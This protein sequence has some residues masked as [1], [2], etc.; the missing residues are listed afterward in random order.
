MKKTPVLFVILILCGFAASSQTH[1]SGLI[2]AN[3]TWNVAGSPYI[4][5]G[6]TLIQSGVK[7]IVEAGVT[8]KFSDN[9]TLLI[10]G[11]LDAQGDASNHILFTSASTNPSPGHWNN[12]HFSSTS[13]PATFNGDGTYA[14]G[15]IMQYCD[16][17]YGGQ[18]GLGMLEIDNTA[19][20]IVFCSVQYSSCDG[21]YLK[22]GYSKIHHCQISNNSGSGIYSTVTGI[23][24][25]TE[26]YSTR[27]FS[28]GGSGIYVAD[29][30][31]KF[32]SIKSCALTGNSGNGIYIN[33][34][35]GSGSGTINIISDTIADNSADKGAG[36]YINGGFDIN[37]FCNTI[38]HNT[39]NNGS[40]IYLYM[41]YNPYDIRISYNDIHNN[42]SWSGD[43]I[44]LM[45]YTSYTT[46][47][48]LSSNSICSNTAS[49]GNAVIYMKGGIN[50]DI[51]DVK[52][53][54]IRS[55]TGFT[56]FEL[57][58]FNGHINQNNFINDTEYEIYNENPAGTVNV[59]AMDNYWYGITTMDARIY[60]FF[61]N[62]SIS[63][64]YYSPVYADSIA[65]AGCPQNILTHLEPIRNTASGIKVYPNPSNDKITVETTMINGNKR[66]SI[67]NV[68][69]QVMTEREISEPSVQID[70]STFPAGVYF[71]RM[72]GEKPVEV[73]K[74]LKE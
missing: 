56:T 34:N 54:T 21:I 39:G 28:N 73:V 1:I 6:N 44:Y 36:I 4:I 33:S 45:F 49:S 13:P 50:T 24:S 57:S 16:L 52:Y 48:E 11:E 25:G 15:S 9:T 74:L 38:S 69:G 42:T 62:G 68:N 19:P 29:M 12:I 59:P 58:T 27:I 63:V 26:I 71:I 64:V 67:L 41:G 40:A 47:V 10:D 70:I 37:I 3:A 46:L 65:L 7:I 22:K 53:N 18:L 43:V 8:V 35:G 23:Y 2:A 31:S 30:Y 17:M 60:D 72:T 14:S 55:N 20:Y 5:D 61:D 66:L 32:I 51:Y